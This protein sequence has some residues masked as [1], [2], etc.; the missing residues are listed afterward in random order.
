MGRKSYYLVLGVSRTESPRGIRQ[1]FRELVKRYHPDRV[2]LQG[3][4]F[5]QEIVE[6]YRVL[7]D[8]ERRW[9]YDQGLVH[10]EPGVRMSGVPIFLYPDPPSPSPLPQV[11]SPLHCLPQGRAAFEAAFA[12]VVRSLTALHAPPEESWEGIDIQAILSP[13]EA[14]RGGVAFLTVPSCA[15]CQTCGG[16][17]REGLFVCATCDGAGLLEG[18][19]TVRV[20][21]PS[22]VGDAT[23]LDVPLRGLGVHHFYLR[24][25]LRVA[26]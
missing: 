4:H 23:L 12:R 26:A 7:A 13:D 25:H 24:L 5:F 15:P 6:A 8:P 9:H 19:E 16:S 1:A 2:G 22:L 3:L 20:V 14:A 18:E 21:V 11:V 17:G 10:A